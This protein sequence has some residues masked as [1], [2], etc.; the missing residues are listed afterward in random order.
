MPCAG[1]YQSKSDSDEAS[2]DS[3]CEDNGTHNLQDEMYLLLDAPQTFDF[4]P[5]DVHAMDGGHSAPRRKETFEFYQPFQTEVGHAAEQM[6]VIKPAAAMAA[7]PAMPTLPSDFHGSAHEVPSSAPLA[8]QPISMA[9]IY[10][11]AETFKA[12]AADTSGGHSA[13]ELVQSGTDLVQS[14]TGLVQ[15]GASALELGQK[16]DGGI[17]LGQSGGH[18]SAAR[19]HPV[20]LAKR[21]SSVRSPAP[22]AAQ[23]ASKRTRGLD[24]SKERPFACTYAS[25]EKRYTKSSHLKAHVRTHTGERPFSCKWKGC[26]W[27][28]ARSDELTRHYRKHTGARPYV[29][30]QCQR[31]FARSDHLAAHIKTHTSATA[32]ARSSP[33]G[34]SG[35]TVSS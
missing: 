32:H 35:S 3:Q 23:A 1:L 17:G 6:D 13:T 24:M 33:G 15:S 2:N 28:F 19:L 5:L 16:D 20:R 26:T 8:S 29:C 14:S 22:S 27:K 4:P 12:F 10:A 31:R 30:Q 21:A 7:T 34:P 25:C 9:T 11:L 18:L